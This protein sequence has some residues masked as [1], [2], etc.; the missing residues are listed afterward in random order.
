[1]GIAEGTN[2]Q[3]HNLNF[4]L[5]MQP[6]KHVW[7][8][9]ILA[10]TTTSRKRN[11]NHRYRHADAEYFADFSYPIESGGPAYDSSLTLYEETDDRNALNYIN[12]YLKLRYDGNQW[13]TGVEL[14]YDHNA[15]VRHVFWPSTLMESVSYVSDFSG[16]NR[17]VV[18]R[19]YAG[20]TFDFNASDH[21]LNVQVETSYNRDL[22]KYNY[23]KAF[24]GSNDKYK[25]TLSGG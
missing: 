14:L 7:V 13:K 12:G 11:Q 22:N 24:D 4:F 3:R 15:D 23:T 2:Y 1:A 18:L 21:L 9:A 6:L 8:D 20:Y 17:R 5:T 25:T 16:V 10:G 19:G